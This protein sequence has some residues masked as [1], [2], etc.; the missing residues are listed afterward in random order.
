MYPKERETE[1]NSQ[2]PALAKEFWISDPSTLGPLVSLSHQTGWNGEKR[3]EEYEYIREVEKNIGWRK[4]KRKK[5]FFYWNSIHLFEKKNNECNFVNL[6]EKSFWERE[7]FNI[8]KY[9]EKYAKKKKSVHQ[10]NCLSTINV[11]RVEIEREKKKK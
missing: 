7:K 10:V 6:L 1:P 9:K 11:N 8:L 2:L 3:F 5:P 4:K